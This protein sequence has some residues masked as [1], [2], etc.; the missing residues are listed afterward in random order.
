MTGSSNF[1]CRVNIPNCNSLTKVQSFL[2]TLT[3]IGSLPQTLRV[4]ISSCPARNTG[5][6][7]DNRFSMHKSCVCA[8]A[9]VY[10]RHS[11]CVSH[12]HYGVINLQLTIFLCISCVRVWNSALNQC[13]DFVWENILQ[14]YSIIIGVNIVFIMEI[15]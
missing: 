2:K 9:C 5:K 7:C 11:C 6:Y 3:T 12:V 4:S 14:Q 8:C 15:M 10:C 13:T 1:C